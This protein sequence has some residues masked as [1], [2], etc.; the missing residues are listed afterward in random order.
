[1]TTVA[2]RR[3][4]GMPVPLLSAAERDRATRCPLAISSE[5][6]VTFFPLSGEEQEQIPGHAG[7]H[8]RLGCAL[9][10]GARRRMGFVPD[11][12]TSTP[13]EAVPFVARQRAVAP[14]GL[15]PSTGSS[16]PRRQHRQTM[17][18]DL[19]SRSP[20]RE[21]L[22]RL[23]ACLME[24][25]LAHDKPRLLAERLCEPGQTEQLLRPGVTR[26]ERLVA[27]ARTR[28]ETATCRQRT[29]RRTA[30]RR[31]GRD[32]LLEPVPARTLTPLTWLRRPALSHSPRAIV[33]H[34]ETLAV[35]RPA[36]LAAWTREPLHPNRRK[37]LAPLSRT[38]SAQAR[39]RAPVRRR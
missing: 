34:L 38:S 8:A 7:L 14:E 6:L 32:R 16:H 36:G 5:A 31:Q 33:A 27:P 10:R 30:D 13:P 21:A 25:A 4:R 18:T 23:A 1:M 28:A 17:Q 26:R 19:G 3:E 20:R 12:R 11:D 9:A 39:H 29:P 15:A 35:L 2:L 37:F 22:E 24:R